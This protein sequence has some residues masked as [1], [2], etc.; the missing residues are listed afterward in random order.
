MSTPSESFFDTRWGRVGGALLSLALL[1]A[2]AIWLYYPSLDDAMRSF[3]DQAWLRDTTVRNSFVTMFDPRVRSAN[4]FSTTYYLPLQSALFWVMVELFGRSAQAFHV[5][6]LGIHVVAS[7]L[8]YML[9]RALTR[10]PW[11]ALVA[12]LLFVGHLGHVQ[13]VTWVS[14]TV[15]HPLV[16]VFIVGTMLAW[17]RYLETRRRVYYGVALGSLVVGLLIR[18][19]AVIVPVL[20]ALLEGAFAL[21]A[22]P[23][24]ALKEHMAR[25]GRALVKYAPFVLVAAPIVA[26]SVYK[27]PRGS[28]H[29]KWGGV[30]LGVHPLL[31]LLD[32]S[33]LLVY[34]VRQSASLKLGLAGG[35]ILLGWCLFYVFRRRPL[36][37]FCLLW[38]GI[39]L[40]P[41]TLSNFNEARH[42]MRYLYPA[43]VG[44]VLLLALW[45][46]SAVERA[47]TRRWPKLVAFGL[48]VAYT[49]WHLY[50]LYQ[51]MY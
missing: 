50:K 38:I 31:R 4:P 42:I 33:S 34:P 2:V 9:C 10:N 25:A 20:M 18:E 11:V 40:A 22:H 48:F 28:L 5:L 12:G 45:C 27:Y 14:A 17:V 46:T 32:F 15:S 26:I 39:G 35:L 3:D 8:V 43:S 44:Y 37:T 19:S 51:R 21:R 29:Q 24:R 7:G 49:L 6:C 23:Q 47:G 41:Y 13:S 1:A 16:T 36:W 30:S